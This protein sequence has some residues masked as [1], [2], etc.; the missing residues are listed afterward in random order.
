MATRAASKASG[1]NSQ[2]FFR[3]GARGRIRRF[4]K[5]SPHGPE[6]RFVV[7][8]TS[9]RLGRDFHPLAAEHARRTTNKGRPPVADG[10]SSRKFFRSYDN[11]HTICQNLPESAVTSAEAEEGQREKLETCIPAARESLEMHC[12]A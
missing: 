3:D 9:I 7:R 11:P 10:P 5:L 1:T 2:S 8:H 12:V 6:V 4:S